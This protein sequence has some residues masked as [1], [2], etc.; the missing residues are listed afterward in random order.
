M[1]SSNPNRREFISPVIAVLFDLINDFASPNYDIVIFR[2]IK[3]EIVRSF[4]G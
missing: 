3:C 4:A 2:R 1:F